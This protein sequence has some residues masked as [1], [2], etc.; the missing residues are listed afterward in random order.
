MI[1]VHRWHCSVFGQ[2]TTE[3]KQILQIYLLLFLF[4]FLLLFISL[5][6]HLINSSS[7]FPLVL[8]TLNLFELDF[9]IVSIT[10]DLFVICVLVQY[11][12]H[13]LAGQIDVFILQYTQFLISWSI[14]NHFYLF[15]QLC[16]LLLYDFILLMHHFFIRH[17]I[18][19]SISIC[20]LNCYL[21]HLR[22]HLWRHR[23]ALW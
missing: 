17:C 22:L 6:I 3:F 18:V 5:L 16:E 23:I 12:F 11:P 8:L 2:L 15:I 20:S 10:D 21:F 4:L 13:V 14:F 19:A 7:Y 1:P 9:R